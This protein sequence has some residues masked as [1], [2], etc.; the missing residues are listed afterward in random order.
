MRARLL[1]QRDVLKL[2]DV[3]CRDYQVLAPFCGRGRDSLYDVVTETNRDQIRL[4]VPNP[5]Y[6]PKRY[7]LPHL[8]RLLRMRQDQGQW[9]LEPEYAHKPQAIFG[10]RSC[11]LAGI[12][13]LDRFYL[14]RV[15][16][17]LLRAAA[18]R[19]V[20]GQHGLHGLPG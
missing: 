15:P 17:C 14:G 5:L 1:D 7:V 11:D 6:P 19:P 4:H 10:I 18:A 8:E 13:H 16:R 2:V 20:P 9:S 3:L 12:W